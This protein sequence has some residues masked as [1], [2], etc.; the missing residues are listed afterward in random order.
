MTTNALVHV[1]RN[2][3]FGMKFIAPALKLIKKNWNG[4]MG[5]AGTIGGALFIESM[6]DDD[7]DLGPLIEKE[8]GHEL[9]DDEKEYAIQTL[10]DMADDVSSDDI[11]TPYSK[12]LNEY[13]QP[14][15]MVI[16]LQ[17]Q[18]SWFTNNYISPNYVKAIKRN[19]VSR[20]STFR[21]KR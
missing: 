20:G 14:T 19:T 11:F 21:R 18:K 12:R 4:V 7:R 10:K 9:T 1:A 17:S 15:H 6:F 3:A 16:D 5:H 2:R 8:I 13:V